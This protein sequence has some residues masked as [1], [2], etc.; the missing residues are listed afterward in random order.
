[1]V[2]SKHGGA[3]NPENFQRNAK[4]SANFRKFCL[5]NAHFLVHVDIYGVGPV[6]RTRVLTRVLVRA[7]QPR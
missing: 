1:M 6:Y 3:E 5:K 2:S 7:C 4:K